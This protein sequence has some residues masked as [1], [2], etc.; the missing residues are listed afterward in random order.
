MW[1]E[2]S[3]LLYCFDFCPEHPDTEHP[4]TSHHTYC[5]HSAASSLFL[6]SHSL[7]LSL[8]FYN[9]FPQII[10]QTQSLFTALD[11]LRPIICSWSWPENGFQESGGTTMSGSEYLCCFFFAQWT[12]SSRRVQTCQYA[13][14][15]RF[16]YLKILLF[17]PFTN[18]FTKLLKDS[19]RSI[20]QALGE[21]FLPA[22]RLNLLFMYMVQQIRVKRLYCREFPIFKPFL[23]AALGRKSSSSDTTVE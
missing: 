12:W 8:S 2:G 17:L 21:D 14:I 3:C 6:L 5:T 20:K 22:T 13:L 18:V 10:S 16:K 1:L 11:P 19:E 4:D 7:P 15:T 23:V 9:L